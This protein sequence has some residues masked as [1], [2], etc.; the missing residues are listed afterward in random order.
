MSRS[1]TTLAGTKCTQVRLGRPQTSHAEKGRAKDQRR[2]ECEQTGT[3]RTVSEPL[4]A[5]APFGRGRQ[6]RDRSRLGG[7]VHSRNNLYPR[8]TELAYELGMFEPLPQDFVA[9][10]GRIC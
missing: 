10:A 9:V 2:S 3:S 4:D 7:S 8:L 5:R 1:N 6:G